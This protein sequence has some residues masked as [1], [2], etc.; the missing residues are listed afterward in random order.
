LAL[1]SAKKEAREWLARIN[2]VLRSE[3][4]PI[5]CGV[6]EDEYESYAGPVAALLL[7][8]APDSD[9]AAYLDRVETGAMGLGPALSSDRFKNVI[10]A[11][12]ALSVPDK[13]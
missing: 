9:I 6:P 7:K 8:D 11:L 12:R 13:P 5:G 3:W 10:A 2:S 4:D 1:P